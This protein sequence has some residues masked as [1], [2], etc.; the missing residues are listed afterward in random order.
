MGTS[1]ARLLVTDA[2]LRVLGH[3]ERAYGMQ[4]SSDGRAE[5]DPDEILSACR[6]LFIV[7]ADR[8]PDDSIVIGLASVMH[9][10]IALDGENRPLSPLVS[11]ADTR[12]R[13]QTRSLAEEHGTDFFYRRTGCPVHSSYWPGKISW[14]QDNLEQKPARFASVK[15]YLVHALTGQW[16]VDCGIAATS[17]LVNPTALSYDEEV[18]SALGVEQAQLSA[19]HHGTKRFHFSVEGRK[20]EAVLGSSDGALANLGS[21][22][23]SRPV[24]TVG[25]S[26]AVRR[27]VGTPLLDPEARAWC[28][29]LDHD[30]FVIGEASNSGGLVLSWLAKLLGFEDVQAMTER[31]WPG[32]KAPRTRVLCLPTMLAER[33]PGY[34]ES[35]SGHFSG[36]TTRHHR[37]DL[38]L[39]AIEGVAFFARLMFDD[40]K[41][42]G[43]DTDWDGSTVLTGGTG[44][45]TRFS[46]LAAH[47]LGPIRPVSGTHPS[48]AFGAAMLAMKSD[49]GADYAE[50]N[51]RMGRPAIYGPHREDGPTDRGAGARG[52]GAQDESGPDEDWY[53]AYL[54]EKYAR[55]RKAYE[56]A[57]E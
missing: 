41:R 31:A 48:T 3:E 56:R 19:I 43:V 38:A 45:G 32:P 40:L 5:Q 21:G 28:Y 25:S 6:E 18:L 8:F 37:E 29:P 7:A 20:F 26:S 44:S 27:T 33:A 35:L 12:A 23:G 46:K 55:F 34:A 15:E 42:V 57:H 10:L 16:M 49:T 36:L 51:L 14:F 22:A 50:L 54:E 2:D 47:L 53:T 52:D 17:G 30:L 11:W 4:T 24:L 13:A 9:S 1:G 39:A